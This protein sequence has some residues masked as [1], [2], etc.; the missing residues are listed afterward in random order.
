VVEQAHRRP[1]RSS[2]A[3]FF[4][5][6]ERAAH[7]APSS[8]RSRGALSRALRALYVELMTQSGAQQPRRARLS[9]LIAGAGSS[10]GDKISPVP[11]PHAIPVRTC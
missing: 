5:V 4:G 11:S 7:I 1:D 9:L 10:V 8:V 2:S 6:G 3:S